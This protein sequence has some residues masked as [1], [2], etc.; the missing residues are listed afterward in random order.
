MYDTDMLN[1]NVKD[2]FYDE[3]KLDREFWYSY[4]NYILNNCK[5]NFART[6]M[7][8][9]FREVM[10]DDII[11]SLRNKDYSY[12]N[13]LIE[14]YK[15]FFEDYDFIY[16]LSKGVVGHEKTFKEKKGKVLRNGKRI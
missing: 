9:E 4:P 7:I 16:Y 1:K 5:A 10:E 6:I 11:E 2:T 3:R 15:L 12:V 14:L 8:K 13:E